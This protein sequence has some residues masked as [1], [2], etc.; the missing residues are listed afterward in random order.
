MIFQ[1]TKSKKG[2]IYGKLDWIKQE[3]TDLRLPLAL[4]L[5][6]VV[7]AHTNGDENEINT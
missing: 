4:D 5:G 6:Q 7:E 3:M 1:S 2:K